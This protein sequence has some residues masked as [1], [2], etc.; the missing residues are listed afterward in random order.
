MQA[1]L[2]T[3]GVGGWEGS[4]RGASDVRSRGG[5]VDVRSVGQGQE[6]TGRGGDGGK[7]GI[8]W[9]ETDLMG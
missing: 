4:V 1:E 9:L 7:E 2:W 8:G 3:G 6:W 5:V